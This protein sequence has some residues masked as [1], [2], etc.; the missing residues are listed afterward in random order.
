[1]RRAPRLHD[2]IGLLVTAVAAL[3][4]LLSSVGWG[5]AT[6]EA[7]H[8][9][10]EAAARVAE[11][12]LKVLAAEA[13]ADPERLTARLVAVGR[14]R[15]NQ[16]EVIGADGTLHYRSPEPTYK[17]GREAPAWFA[18]L[19]SPTV[20]E[21]RL[22]AGERWLVLRPDVSRSVLDAWD[23]L[24]LIGGWAFGLLAL[25]WLAVRRAIDRALA[26]LAALDTALARGA[27]GSFDT[28]LPRHGVAELDGLADSY[29]RLAEQ[30][31]RSLLRNA[32]LEEDQAFARALT[33]RLEEERRQLARDLHDEL[34][35]SVTAV[36]AIAGAIAQRSTEHPTL[37][38]SAQAILAM[39]GQMQDGVRAIL[40]RLRRPD[41]L[42]AGRLGEALG[43]YCRHWA[44]LYPGV[45]LSPRLDPVERA[46]GEDFC[47]TV[48]RLLQ[49]SLTN[50]ARHA[51]ASH[52]CVDLACKADGLRLVVSDDGRGFDATLRSERYGLAGMRE[53]VAACRGEITIE[54]MAGGGTR[55]CAQLPW[56]EPGAVA[57]GAASPAAPGVTCA[58]SVPRNNLPLTR[59]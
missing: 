59:K 27:D 40:Q 52:V 12:W 10:V 4:L 44:G 30:L 51:E 5:R 23:E 31:D 42:P 50:V 35:Q 48:L 56:P 11:Q 46:L 34:G 7:I 16:L 36:R 43:Q 28:R 32:R 24:L 6:R 1:M 33:A 49:E 47:L 19:M 45:T 21:R 8:E 14:L 54:A 37:H 22:P 25:L 20:A 18:A 9:E 55:I 39:T 38:G 15:A 41:A 53:R 29:N 13:E 26:P 3:L 2:R 58:P 57:P 17:A